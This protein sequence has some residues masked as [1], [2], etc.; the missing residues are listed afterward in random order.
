MGIYA[1]QHP[2]HLAKALLGFSW[3]WKI[4]SPG[5]GSFLPDAGKAIP[6]ERI[7]SESREFSLRT[8]FFKIDIFV[9]VIEPTAGGG[10]I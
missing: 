3:S 4:G 1:S 8:F 5:I 7:L 6:E 9:C 2:L 10:M